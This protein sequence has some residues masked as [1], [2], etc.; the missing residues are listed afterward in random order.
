MKTVLAFGFALSMALPAAAQQNA[1]PAQPGAA[2]D[3]AWVQSER[4]RIANAR[5][6]AEQRYGEQ[7]R[8]CWQRFAV[9]DCL[10]AAQRERR[11]A[12]DVLRHE[13]LALNAHERQQRVAERLRAI[14]E[15]ARN[16]KS[17]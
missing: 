17:D 8:A 15:K 16:G 3:Q 7:E 13:E 5:A 2:T 11:A 9:N 1:A 10:H 6:A 14:E 12:L 4:T